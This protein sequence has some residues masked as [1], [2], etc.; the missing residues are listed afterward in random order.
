[1]PYPSPRRNGVFHR[2]IVTRCGAWLSLRAN[3]N[4]D[5]LKPQ[6]LLEPEGR[7]FREVLL[8]RLT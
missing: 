4:S 6:Q 5:C 7:G 2:R 8:K 1:M 3:T